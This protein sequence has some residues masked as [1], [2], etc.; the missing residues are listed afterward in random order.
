MISDAVNETDAPWLFI[1]M[2]DEYDEGTNLIPA[3]DDPPVP[4]T[5]SGG[6]PLDLP[7]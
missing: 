3:S 1:G 5:D 4:D 2:F 6:N 7:G